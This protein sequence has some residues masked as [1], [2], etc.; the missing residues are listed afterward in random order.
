MDKNKTLQ[1]LGN[2]LM[3]E[4]ILLGYDSGLV[5]EYKNPYMAGSVL[6]QQYVTGYIFGCIEIRWEEA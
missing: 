5:F 4:A 6:W 3:N 1:K 2:K